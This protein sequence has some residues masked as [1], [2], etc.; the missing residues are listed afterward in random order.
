MTCIVGLVHDNTVYLGGD[1]AGTAGWDMTVRSDP[2]VFRNGPF[3]IG[4][5]TS[6]RMGQLLR[7]RFQPPP[8]HPPEMDDLEFMATAF[9]DGVRQCFKDYGYTKIDSS[10][11][12]GGA[13]LVGYRGRLYS[14][15]SDFQVGVPADPFDAAGCGDQVARGAMFVQSP[16]TDPRKRITAALMAAERFSAGV[17]GPF[18]IEELAP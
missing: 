7:F 6:F 16:D 17:R 4:Y 5:T 18:V 10:R 14:V 8:H 3:L 12:E 1:S 2:K 9:V 13:F 11:E 15:G